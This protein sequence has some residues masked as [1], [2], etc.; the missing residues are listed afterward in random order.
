[1][2]D[3]ENQA[4]ESTTVQAKSW[5]RVALRCLPWALLALVLPA[6]PVAYVL[7]GISGNNQVYIRLRERE[8]ERI[9]ELMT[10]HPEFG[11]LRIESASKPFPVW[12]EGELTKEELD[13]LIG[14]LNRM[15][16]DE[17]AS[18]MIVTIEVID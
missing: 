15:F 6:I 7:G 9:R 2:S 11:K 5:S 12:L 3:G 17:V 4:G 10:E 13:E 16:G 18:Q 8:E 14:H 1:M